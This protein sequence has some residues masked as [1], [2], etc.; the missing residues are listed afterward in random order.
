MAFLPAH[1]PTDENKQRVEMLVAFGIPQEAIAKELGITVDTLAKYYR[2]ELD[3]GLHKANGMVAGKLF[4]KAV[5]DNDL[6]AQ[7]FW[8]KTRAR[9]KEQKDDP[10]ASSGSLAEQVVQFLIEQNK[11]KSKSE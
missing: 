1:Q 8:L 3:F 6:G 7:I 2:H 11:N 4:S 9:W 5:Y 10:N